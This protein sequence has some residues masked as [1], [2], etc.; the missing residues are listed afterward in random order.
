MTTVSQIITDAYRQSNLL[1]IGVTPT[2][3]Q[4]EEGLRYLNRLV[5]SVFGNEAGENFQAYPLGDNNIERPAGYPW[6]NNAPGG[7]WFVPMN[8]RLACN[9]TLPTTVYLHPKP[10]DGARLGVIDISQN[11]STNELTLNANG[12]RINGLTSITLSTNGVDQEWFFRGDLGEW[13]LYAP[14]TDYAGTFPFPEEFD[15]F[16]IIILAMALNPAYGTQMDAQ[17]AETFRRAKTQLRA[18]YSNRIMV[19]SEDALVRMPKVA[20]D[21]DLWGNRWYYYDPQTA[22][23]YGVPW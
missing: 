23:F 22:F 4:L 17:T 19:G 7:N 13:M 11:F 5:K 1:P 18:R 16:F 6:Y 21:R 8:V 20:V 2:A 12:R 15:F 10:E 9:L 14:L 3:A